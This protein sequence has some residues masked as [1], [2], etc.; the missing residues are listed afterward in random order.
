[1]KASTPV[2]L[3]A[4]WAQTEQ[5]MARLQQALSPSAEL[6]LTI[7]CCSSLLSES[8]SNP[9][10]PADHAP[11][12][13]TLALASR[14]GRQPSPTVLVGWS[15]GGMVALE[16][17]IHFPEL[18]SRLVLISSCSVFCPPTTGREDAPSAPVRALILGLQRD[19]NET[20]R[21]FFSLMHSE[22]GC[23]RAVSE[24]V[25]QALEIKPELLVY[26]LRYIQSLDLRWGLSSV[27]VPTLIIHGCNDRVI[28]SDASQLLQRGLS[29][30]ELL[31][32]EHADHGLAATRPHVLA[33]AIHRFFRGHPACV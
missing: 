10:P 20:L 12:D 5:A 3:I 4:G 33:S 16:T 6:V 8:P 28:S 19:R 30:S 7:S 13:Y 29:N 31:L 15:M 1:V 23:D 22:S 18:V 11:S 14:L 21:R 32:I 27:H 24:S 26:G 9:D 25:R 17:A 2:I